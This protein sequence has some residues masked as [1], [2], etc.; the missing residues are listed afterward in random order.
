M[1]KS[2]AGH[3]R[4]HDKPIIFLSQQVVLGQY[5]A[6]VAVAA[7]K[8]PMIKAIL[9]KSFWEKCGKLPEIEGAGHRCEQF[10]RDSE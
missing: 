2:E 3:G 4:Q 10:F 1:F 8:L 9:I 5:Y 6:A 7:D